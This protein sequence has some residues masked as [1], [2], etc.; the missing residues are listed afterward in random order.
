MR[1]SGDRERKRERA[2]EGMGV[3]TEGRET[4]RKTGATPAGAGRT[5]LTTK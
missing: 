4:A 3:R 5:G 1:G 2:G